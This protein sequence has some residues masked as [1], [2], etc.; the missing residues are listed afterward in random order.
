MAMARNST[1][2][3]IRVTDQYSS[4]TEH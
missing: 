4:G 2:A 3:D 1:K